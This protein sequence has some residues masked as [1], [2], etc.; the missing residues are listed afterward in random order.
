M[1]NDVLMK[2]LERL[3]SIETRI[4]ELFEYR[5]DVKVNTKDIT[6]LKNKTENQQKQIDEMKESNK[7]LS[8]G[9]ITMV[10]GLIGGFLKTILGI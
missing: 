10:I 3:A 6:D 9:V 7:W 8:R 4:T 2:I 5:D 1:D